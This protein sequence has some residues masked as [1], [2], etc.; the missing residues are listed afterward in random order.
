MWSLNFLVA[1]LE[2]WMAGIAC[3]PPFTGPISKSDATDS[4]LP[5]RQQ[6]LTPI[7][8]VM[9]R[10]P[11]CPQLNPASTNTH[12]SEPQ[13]RTPRQH[14][15]RLQARR[16]CCPHIVNHSP[17][18]FSPSLSAFIH[19]VNVV[20]SLIISSNVVLVVSVDQFRVISLSRQI[21]DCMKFLC[22]EGTPFPRR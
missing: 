17:M 8:F 19:P 18:Q 14:N 1:R 9:A 10:R 12:L 20:L 3:G 2:M 16:C 5:I 11:P 6:R 4:G 13:Q 15:S 21:D 7:I 22:L